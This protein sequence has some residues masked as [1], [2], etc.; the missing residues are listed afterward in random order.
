MGLYRRRLIRLCSQSYMT[1]NGDLSC[2]WKHLL[3]Y[4]FSDLTYHFAFL[5]CLFS[6]LTYLFSDLTYLFSEL[7]YR[8]RTLFQ[9]DLT[10]PS[11][12][13]TVSTTCP[14]ELTATTSAIF[15]AT[16]KE[17]TKEAARPKAA[18][19]LLRWRPKA[20]IFVVAMN[21]VDVVAVNSIGQVVLTGARTDGY[22]KLIWKKVVT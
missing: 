15:I 2:R 3:T 17:T 12:W 5:T 10:Y 4:P 1:F 22:V 7:A 9:I 19:P 6:D 18:P 20:A 16:T 8:L 21:R 11:V 14:I 13:A